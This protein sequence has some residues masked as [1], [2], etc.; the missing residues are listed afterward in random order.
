MTHTQDEPETIK[1]LFAQALPEGTNSH[2][3]ALGEVHCEA[4]HL[5][6]LT[7]N[8]EELDK[9]HN[10]GTVGLELFPYMNVFL[11]A[12]RDGNL[13]VSESQIDNYLAAVFRSYALPVNGNVYSAN[14]HLAKAAIDRGMRAVCFDARGMLQDEVSKCNDTCMGL[15]FSDFVEQ[16]ADKE[17]IPQEKLLEALRNDP[18]KVTSRLAQSCGNV[19]AHMKIAAFGEILSSNSNFPYA[20]YYGDKDVP[21]NMVRSR[22][23][24]AWMVNEARLLLEQHPEY[25]ARLD[26]MESMILEGRVKGLP[27]DA[28][29]SAIFHSS[30]DRERNAISM[31]GYF[32]LQGVNIESLQVQGTAD[33]HLQ[34][35]PGI[36]RV[37][38]AIIASSSKAAQVLHRLMEKATPSV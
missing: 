11:W 2:I 16:A 5:N 31:H 23:A 12:Y 36:H 24:H 33:L 20:F 6:I 8:L 32:H 7:E 30:M 1:R 38:R 15:A 21:A 18:S 29:S 25:Q 26:A 22:I 4:G 14:S 10:L 37:S 9:R 35:M 28:I 34:S 3:L 27:E 13:P 17:G 19:L